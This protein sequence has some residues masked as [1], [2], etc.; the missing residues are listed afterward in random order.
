VPITLNIKFN[1]ARNDFDIVS[2][3]AES[4]LLTKNEMLSLNL[5]LMLI[6]P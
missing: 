3:S 1:I 2:V 6:Q 4:K 5:I